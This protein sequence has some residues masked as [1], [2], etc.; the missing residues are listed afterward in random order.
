M[1]IDMKMKVTTDTNPSIRTMTA[2]VSLL[3]QPDG[4]ASFN[5]G[6]KHVVDIVHIEALMIVGDIMLSG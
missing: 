4:S 5:Q 6:N 1:K 2:E 3:S